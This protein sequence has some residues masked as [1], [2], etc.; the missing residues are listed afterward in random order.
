MCKESENRNESYYDSNKGHWDCE[1]E[2]DPDKYP[3][4]IFENENA[5]S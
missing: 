2:N 3:F 1:C 4:I 5:F